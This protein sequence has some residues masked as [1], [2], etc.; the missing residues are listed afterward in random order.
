MTVEHVQVLVEESDALL[1]LAESP[2]CF[3]CKQ[4]EVHFPKVAGTI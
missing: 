1:A 3:F 2:T 4:D